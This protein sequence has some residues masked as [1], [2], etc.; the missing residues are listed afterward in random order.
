MTSKHPIL[1]A[2]KLS[3]SF[4]T[5]QTITVLKEVSLTLYPG[6]SIAITGP[7]GVGKSTLLHILGT[8]E[9]PS[10]GT[11]TIAD[12]DVLLFDPSAVRNRH[13]GFIFQNFNLLPDYTALENV[14][15]PGRIGRQSIRKASASL[16]RG[17]ELLTRISLLERA[18]ELSR[19][20]S[21]GEKQ[22]IAI[23]RA[24]YND[25]DLILADE[26]SGNLDD[27]HSTAI[28]SLLFSLTEQMGKAL[29]IVTHDRALA[30]LCNRR[31]LLKNG[32]LRE[33]S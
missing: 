30:A 10:S 25:P 18:H 15:M 14:L 4:V 8:L 23:A 19:H 17:Y 13:I 9:R 3:K 28:H 1:T 26:P 16:E 32:S 6:E 33:E 27:D 12:Q 7:S 29:V 5:N 31:F 11:L 21:G 24:L 22:R 2:K 20:L